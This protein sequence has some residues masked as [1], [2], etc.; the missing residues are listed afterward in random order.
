MRAVRRRGDRRQHREP[1][2]AELDRG[3]LR[4]D[5]AIVRRR[6]Q[7]VEPG[8]GRSAQLNH[9]A[10]RLLGLPGGRRA[11]PVGRRPLEQFGD[12]AETIDGRAQLARFDE[13]RK[14][15]DGAMAAVERESGIELSLALGR[16]R[17]DR[18]VL[19]QTGDEQREESG[20]CGRQ[21]S[22]LRAQRATQHTRRAHAPAHAIAPSRARSPS[23]PASSV[24]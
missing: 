1:P 18:R 17:C 12:R 23:R 15:G 9:I 14:L 20:L 8:L 10:A 13:R 6:A 4:G 16:S 5:Q 11:D 7:A 19:G 24:A 2:L 3:L 21:S 22:Q